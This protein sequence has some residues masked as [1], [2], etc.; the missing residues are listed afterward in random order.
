MSQQ[1]C[2]LCCLATTC[3]APAAQ[4]PRRHARRR[5]ASGRATG[6]TTGPGMWVTGGPALCLQTQ[7]GAQAP[8][9]GA[10]ENKLTQSAY[11]TPACVW[12][13]HEHRGATCTWEILSQVCTC[14]NVR[15]A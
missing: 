14:D 1:P 7:R 11:D 10:A 2:V 3:S 12:K 9:P 13:A 5:D 8:E 6:W 4:R 15:R